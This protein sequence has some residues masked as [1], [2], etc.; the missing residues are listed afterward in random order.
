MPLIKIETTAD[1]SA[2][3]ATSTIPATNSSHVPTLP[4]E[5]ISMI[6][7][8]CDP[9]DLKNM[10]LAS[11]LMHQ[12]S[13]EPFARKKF[14]RRRFIFTYQSM[15]ALIDITAH[16]VFGR[17]LTC[18]TFVAEFDMIQAMHKAFLDRNH[19]IRMLTLALKNL[20][21]CHN[22][23]V[24]LGVHD[25]FRGDDLRR[26]GYAFETSF[27][28]YIAYKPHVS[29][30]LDAVLEARRRSDYP[31]TTLKL[32]LSDN[33]N[34]LRQLAHERDNA[35]VS[36]LSEPEYISRLYIQIN[37]FYAKM[38]VSSNLNRLELSRY[39]WDEYIDG[40][41]ELLRFDNHSYGEI[42]EAINSKM[43]QAISIDRSNA[44]YKDFVTFLQMHKDSLKTLEGT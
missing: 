5:V 29:K 2:K 41:C 6:A 39:D 11:K 42:W 37:V 31:L 36:L 34:T 28:G 17:H 22:T 26:R 32:C 30:T 25:D 24:I 9:V 35:L 15:K 20:R 23:S 10:C 19:H 12:V 43:L 8:E 13:T 3:Q 44:V 7:H 27:K 16:T 38:K 18:L 1:L 33:C 14:S 4:N 21:K 40:P